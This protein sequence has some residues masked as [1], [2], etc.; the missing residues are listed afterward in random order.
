M[1][2]MPETQEQFPASAAPRYR[3]LLSRHACIHARKNKP[4]G[5]SPLRAW[6]LSPMSRPA[7][8]FDEPF[9]T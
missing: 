3:F 6:I 7:T 1:A 8:S 2:G 9:G 4:A 5:L